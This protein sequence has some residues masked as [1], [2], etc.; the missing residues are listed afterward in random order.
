MAVGANQDK[1]PR[2]LIL[3]ATNQRRGAEVLADRLREGLRTRGWIVEL[4][5]LNSVVADG[6]DVESLVSSER[7]R[8]DPALVMALRRRLRVTGADVVL[9]N[10]GA[11]LRYGALTSKRSRPPLVYNSIGEP[12]Y[13]LRSRSA[14]LLNR[15]LLRRMN[16]VFAVSE[17]TRRQLLEIE[18]ALA[19]VVDVAHTGVPV[20]FFD[21][22]RLPRGSR[23][24]A[25]FIGSLSGEKNPMLALSA[26][27]A[28]PDVELR[29]V[30]SG[31]LDETLMMEVKR[32]GIEDRVAFVGSIADVRPH[33]AWAD[34]ILQTSTTE[35][36]PGAVMEAAA[37]GVMAIATDVGG[38]REVVLADESGILVPSDDERSLIEA[39]G[40]AVAD[41]PRVEEM[42]QRAREH[43]LGN[44]TWAAALDRYDSLLRGLIE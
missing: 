14:R 2:L 19:A 32:R 8:L 34:L 5:A 29:F 15:M 12:L 18:P 4:V 39:M 36:L 16:R 40:M 33:L 30:G 31:P 23:L 26:V 7:R 44:F 27:A 35:G 42:G 1:A 37:A 21:V 6:L 11:T 25:V 17:E 10:G 22:E 9:A 20:E 13:W 38:T 24:R 28:V 43:A 3:I 41:R